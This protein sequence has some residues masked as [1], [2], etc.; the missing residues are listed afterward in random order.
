[1]EHTH[2]LSSSLFLSLT[3]TPSLSLPPSLTH[4]LSRSLSRR[5]CEGGRGGF[6]SLSLNIPLS[7]PLFLPLSLI[8]SALLS[9]SL[10]RDLAEAGEG[11]GVVQVDGALQHLL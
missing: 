11:V 7:D 1:M 6:S 5:P 2:A 3:Y 10:A 9:L 4:K 8:R